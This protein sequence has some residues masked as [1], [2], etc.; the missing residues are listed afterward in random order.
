VGPDEN[1]PM[2]GSRE[3]HGRDRRHWVHR[4][5]TVSRGSRAAALL[6]GRGRF[7][8]TLFGVSGCSAD[9][10]ARFALCWRRSD[11][12]SC[13]AVLGR[14]KHAAGLLLLLPTTSEMRAVQHCCRQTDMPLARCETM[15][16]VCAALC[17]ASLRME[18]AGQGAAAWLRTTG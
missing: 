6:L 2:L 1:L 7:V 8:S 3:R 4:N 18:S 11:G 10:R 17:L 9:Y 16:M 13:V 15:A 12:L 5:S 14:G